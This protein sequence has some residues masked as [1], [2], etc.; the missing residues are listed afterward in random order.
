MTTSG[1]IAALL[2]EASEHVRTA[3]A[4]VSEWV[5]P[6]ATLR[7]WSASGPWQEEAKAGDPTLFGLPAETGE[8]VSKQWL[9]RERDRAR[10]E[11]A[12][13]VLVR[14]GP[15][16][17][18]AAP[19]GKVQSGTAPESSV[20]LVAVLAFWT[21]PQPLTRALELEP[22]GDGLVRATARGDAFD[23]ALTVLGWGAAWWELR[24]DT[25][26][27]V[28]LGTTAFGARDEPF[29][30]VTATELAF[31]EPLPDELFKP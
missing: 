26:R 14:D 2:G 6:A 8:T 1:D 19:G 30:R 29:R 5:D 16:W 25:T 28:L 3:R 11:R 7:A 24:I 23:P 31:D 18:S 15:R 17:W 20:D 12:G 21:D 4:T 10:E 22:A 13:V 9:D 27:G